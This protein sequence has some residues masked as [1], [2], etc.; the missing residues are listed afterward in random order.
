MIMK[1][2]S[3]IMSKLNHLKNAEKILNVIKRIRK[4]GGDNVLKACPSIQWSL[5]RSTEK[6]IQCSVNFIKS[7]LSRMCV[8]A[9]LMDLSTV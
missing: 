8:I 1:C 5:H 6:F 7:Y 2:Y 4:G 9:W 3:S